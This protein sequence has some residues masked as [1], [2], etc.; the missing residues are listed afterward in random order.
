VQDHPFSDKMP[1]TLVK[2]VDH[3]VLRVKDPIKSVQWYANTLGLQPVRLEE[4][5]AGKHLYRYIPGSKVHADMLHPFNLT[6]PGKWCRLR[7]ITA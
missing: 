4:F 7:W 6:S 3:I 1:I 2:G 5:Q